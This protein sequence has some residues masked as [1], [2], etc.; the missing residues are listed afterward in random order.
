MTEW[1]AS[2]DW[3]LTTVRMC[4]SLP[5]IPTAKKRT[6]ENT[7]TL[8]WIKM[9]IFC[10]FDW[11]VDNDW[12]TSSEWILATVRM[13]R[14]LPLVVRKSSS[15]QPPPKPF[16]AQGTRPPHLPSLLPFVSD[17]RSHCS[18][19]PD[20]TGNLAKLKK[21][22]GS[23]LLGFLELLGFLHGYLRHLRGCSSLLVRWRPIALLLPA[24]RVSK[25]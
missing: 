18:P 9:T 5:R 12:L 21:L 11:W 7:H 15:A 4:R 22:L 23:F 19:G 6:W 16:S 3:V 14:S 24:H 13:C 1:L 2:T 20:H 25:K 17:P 10:K 8:L